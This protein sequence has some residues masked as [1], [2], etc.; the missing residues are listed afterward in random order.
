[1]STFDESKHPRGQA[2]HPGRF[3]GKQNAAP[4]G[5]LGGAP[6]GP[7][8]VSIL[9]EPDPSGGF[10]TQVDA[11]TGRHF[12]RDSV[13]HREDGPAYEGRDGSEAWYRNG[14]LHRDPQDG[15]AVIDE[16]EDESIEEFYEN[17]QLVVP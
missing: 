12:L 14:K 1:M 3:A 13:P 7:L 5:S 17:G 4:A 11:P 9:A 16:F 2:G 15:P 8:K 10:D 6:I